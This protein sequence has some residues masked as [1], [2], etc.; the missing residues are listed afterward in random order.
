MEV[1]SFCCSEPCYGLGHLKWKVAEKSLNSR[2]Q[3][4]FHIKTRF[5]YGKST[6]WDSS[7]MFM[8]RNFL[9]I[10]SLNQWEGSKS[11]G[12][13]E[14]FQNVFSSKS[15]NESYIP[16]VSSGVGVRNI[17]ERDDLITKVLIPGL[18]DEPNGDCGSPIS[19]CFWEWKPKFSVHYEK[20]GTKNVNSPPI[21]FLPGFGVGSFHYEKQLKDLG[22][23]YRVW[24][25]D[26][27]GQGMSLPT[28]N[29]TPFA[30]TEGSSLD[31]DLVWGFG[32]QT[33]PWAN[34]LVYSIDLWKDQV[35]HFVEEVTLW[36]FNILFAF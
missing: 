15:S 23:E 16:Y 33:E 36:P 18:P 5:V 11:F 25:L 6:K 7:G 12:S 2:Q 8:S 35:H 4:L 14:D 19:S 28:E 3:K 20:S 22:R 30:I 1:F 26:F 17:L 32:E 24:A 27:L 9:R 29:P 21:L 31:Q 34:E 13:L 10:E